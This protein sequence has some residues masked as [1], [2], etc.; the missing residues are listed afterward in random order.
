MNM[1][2]DK[3]EE[4]VAKLLAARDAAPVPGFDETWMAAE[5]RYL[6]EKRKFRMV[7]GVAASLALIAIVIGMAAPDG[8]QT[9]P[10]FELASGLM[11]STLWSAPS[12]ALMPDYSVDIYQDI[13]EMPVSTDLLGGALL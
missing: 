10:E 11:N 2:E 8:Q 12:D 6:V 3:I 13:P 5:A 7:T 4:S 1:S 9:L